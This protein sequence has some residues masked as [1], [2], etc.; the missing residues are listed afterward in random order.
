MLARVELAPPLCTVALAGPLAFGAINVS[1]YVSEWVSEHIRELG[2]SDVR[3]LLH[4]S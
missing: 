1:N 3:L 2:I 4:G